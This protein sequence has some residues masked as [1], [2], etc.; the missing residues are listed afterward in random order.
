VA[1][2]AADNPFVWK[3]MGDCHRQLGHADLARKSYQA[4]LS[5]RPGYAP[6]LEAL[7]SMTSWG[8][9]RARLRRMLKRKRGEGRVKR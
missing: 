6:A 5:R 2:V 7:E 9:L 8:R 1:D 3:L 4:A